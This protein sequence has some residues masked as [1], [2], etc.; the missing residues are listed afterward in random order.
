MPVRIKAGRIKLA[1]ETGRIAAEQV[2]ALVQVIAITQIAVEQV[3]V[4]VREIGV[5]GPARAPWIGAVEAEAIASATRV[6]RVIRPVPRIEVRLVAPVAARAAARL[7]PAV[8]VAPPAWEVPVVAGVAAA[9]AAVAAE[10]EGDSHA[11]H[12]E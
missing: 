6:C 4:P 3:Q 12:H 1:G 11:D 5:P 9:A 7:A 10:D 8:R 2:R